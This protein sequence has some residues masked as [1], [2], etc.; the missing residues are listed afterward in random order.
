VVTGQKERE[1]SEG[2][3]KITMRFGIYCEIQTPP[4]KSHYEMIWE[5][6]HQ[7]EHADEHGL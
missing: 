4:G 3:R 1:K 2:E 7:I 5:I 6:M